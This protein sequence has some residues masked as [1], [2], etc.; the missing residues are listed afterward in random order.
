MEWGKRQNSKIKNIFK[1]NY[2]W[3]KINKLHKSIKIGC[4]LSLKKENELQLDLCCAIKAVAFI[5]QVLD[6]AKET[7]DE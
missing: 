2:C 1:V 5:Q 4:P 3:H 7:A 6:A